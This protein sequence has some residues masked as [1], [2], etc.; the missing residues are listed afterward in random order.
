MAHSTR[1]TRRT[2]FER[3]L[4]P[5]FRNRLLNETTPD[6]FRALCGKV[7]ARGFEFFNTLAKL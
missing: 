7:S 1:A 4:L 3:D 2:L 5:V 6:D